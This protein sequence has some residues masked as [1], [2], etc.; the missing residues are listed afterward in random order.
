MLSEVF[1]NSVM[2]TGFILVMMLVIEYI[3]VLT[4]G[5]W[6]EFLT[7][8]KW[9]QYIIAG[10]MGVIPG[11]L[12]TFTVVT[13][14]SH[15]IVSFG[16]LV[17]AMI[18]TSGDEAFVMLA[19]FPGKALML[20]GILLGIGI[21]AGILTDKFVPSGFVTNKI[22]HNKLPLHK[23][24][25]CVC[26]PKNKIIS[27]L[28]NP[29]MERVLLIVILALFLIAVISGLVGH[30]HNSF[31][32]ISENHSE[33]SSHDHSTHEGHEHT[34]SVE[35]IHENHSDHSEF[36]WIK[37][38]LIITSVLS[39]LIVL[40][41]PQHF[42]K[43]H[44]W[45]HIIKVHIP[46]IFIWTFGALLVIHILMKYIDLQHIIS[47][48][49]LITLFIAVLIGIIP[50]SGPHLLFVTMFFQGLIPFNILLASS[51]VQDGHGMIPVLAESKRGFILVKFINIVVGLSVG[52]IGYYFFQLA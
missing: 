8:K 44:F 37:L 42:L 30:N 1:F 6:Q 4:E 2:I 27:Q 50:E 24:D 22:K 9:V 41:V 38:T 45:D 26:F 51:I 32:K 18:A 39:L 3:N 31:P 12:G 7:G 17:T 40:T 14:F 46:K 33:H 28:K 29:S 13:L 5:L 11:C 47:Q 52:L 16:A 20:F 23:E 10:L 43:H 19:M 25:S 35:H 34:S 21:L 15:R 36:D 48:N 49:M